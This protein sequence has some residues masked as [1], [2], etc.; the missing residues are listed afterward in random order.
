MLFVGDAERIDV[1]DASF[2]AVVDY[3]I[4]HHVPDWRRA[5]REIARVL[6]PGGMFY[7]EDILKGLTENTPDPAPFSIIRRSRSSPGQNS[8]APWRMPVL[9]LDDSWWQREA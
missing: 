1:P 9:Q 3:G 4:L 7:F 2:D 6:K 8:A 5:L